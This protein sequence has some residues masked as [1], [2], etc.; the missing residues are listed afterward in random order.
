MSKKSN[1]QTDLTAKGSRSRG[2]FYAI[3]A[4]I[5][6]SLTPL[7]IK[8]LNTTYG[9]PALMI[10]FWRNILGIALLLPAFLIFKPSLLKLE[11]KHFG[12]IA[13]YGLVFTLLNSIWT[14]LIQFNSAS[15]A[16]VLIYFS[17]PL[18]SFLGWWLLKER[19]SWLKGLAIVLGLGGCALVALAGSELKTNWLGLG[20]GLLSGLIYAFYAIFGRFSAQRGI[21]PWTSTF[22]LF[23]FAMISLFILNVL[24]FNFI[25]GQA[26]DL[27]TLFTFSKDPMAWLNMAL[28]TVPLVVGYGL[29]NQSLTILPSSIA[30]L[31]LTLE[32]PL[33]AILAWLILHEKLLPLQLLGTVLVLSGVLLVRLGVSKPNG[34]V[35]EGALK[36]KP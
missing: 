12:F 6:F 5:L 18:T 16:T 15:V 32:P 27:K 28:L 13:L 36:I 8:I 31:I 10:T 24:P 4:A 30:N 23:F 22:Y 25:P 33:T 26:P 20:L 9:L 19:F 2:F 21:N 34:S 29:F 35:T 11:R 3:V 1:P 17:A 14:F 7:F